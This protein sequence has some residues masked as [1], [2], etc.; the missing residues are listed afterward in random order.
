MSLKTAEA[1][2]EQAREEICEILLARMRKE[3]LTVSRRY[4]GKRVVV[5]SAMGTWTASV[6]MHDG[7]EK[8]IEL[9]VFKL[10][11]QMLD[12]Y[13]WEVIPAPVF[14]TCFN[15]EEVGL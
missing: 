8:E 6:E 7:T 13:G 11:E 4:M 12:K 14:I 15:G 1:A 3:I 10:F 2:I 5:A 9:P